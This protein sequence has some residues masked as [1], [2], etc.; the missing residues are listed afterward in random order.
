MICY[1]NNILCVEAGWLIDEQILSKANYDQLK[2]R[3]HVNVVRSGCRNTPALVSWDSIPTRFKDVIRHKIGGDPYQT[4]KIS[5]LQERITDSVEVS[6]FF[7]D[8]IIAGNLHLPADTQKEYYTNTIILQ[9]IQKLLNDKKALR[10][11]K[12]HKVTRKW[13]DIAQS[14][15]D[16]D[17]KR[18]PH[19][20]P[21]NPRR[22]EDRYKRYIKE[23]PE[24]L[25]HKN[26]MNRNAAKVDD[27]VKE[28]FL[29]QFL[30]DPR[31]LD[32]EQVSRV[33][34]MV[35]EKME[36]KKITAA[37]VAVW[38][39][40]LDTTTYAG[41]RGTVAFSNKKAMQVKRSA[42]TAPL[43]FWTLD[44]WD[45]E[46]LYQKSE[47]GKTTYHHR[48]TVVIVLD[49]CL[50]YPVG[51]AVGTHETP[52]LIQAA[53]RNAEQH[54]VQ[55]FGAM[56]K[57]HQ[58]QSDRYSIKKLTPYYSAVAEK[59][60]PARAKNAKAKIIEPYFNRINK[61]WCQLMPNWSG[62]GITSD[63]DKQPNTEFLN[64]YKTSFPNFEGVC[65]QVSMIVERERA[66]KVERYMELWNAMDHAKQLEMSHESYLLNFGET[67]ERTILM[68]GSGLHPTILGQKRDYDCFDL[69]FREHG[70]TSW[71][72]LYDPEDLS[73]VLAVNEDE[74]LRY[75]LEEKY[76]QP[77]AL[78]ERKPGDSDQLQ[79]IRNFNKQLESSI[80]EKRA[81]STGHVQNVLNQ[82]NLLDNNDTLQKLLITD[83]LG[84]HKDQRNAPR[85][86]SS[87]K[88]LKPTPAT[89]VEDD[90]AEVNIFGMY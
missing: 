28:S 54:T 86:T 90:D 52:E 22:L 87:K 33:Y 67:T 1:Y 69:S 58:I 18:Y 72:V 75:V 77:M 34:N 83:S 64:K 53:L 89:V 7:Q 25:I 17:R 49:A 50:K 55:L 20:L 65:A 66:E 27:E 62:F 16:L 44:G 10:A 14:V 38:R 74:T 88:E 37:A 43:Y 70:S 79:R 29:V 11:A 3:G 60:T 2:S 68:Q 78:E 39:D 24:S 61:K 59:V 40:K 73:R 6:S 15:Q 63:K 41:R 56:Y 30:A 46:L 81:I 76:V 26:F 36:W 13:E 19:T 71:K 8:Y 84:Q 85:R 80:I 47:D 57:A 12:G 21:A 9:A 5:Q 4:V 23:G 51:Y 82:A 42:P 35:A 31:N 32:N 45:V 48:P